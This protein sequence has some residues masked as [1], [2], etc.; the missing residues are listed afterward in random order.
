MAN[1]SNLRVLLMDD[2]PY[3][4]KYHLRWLRDEGIEVFE[5]KSVCEAIDKVQAEEFDLVIA[6]VMIPMTAAYAPPGGNAGLD[7]GVFAVRD[8]RAIK[9]SLKIVVFTN[10]TDQ[11]IVGRITA[12]DERIRILAKRS[13]SPPNFVAE[14]KRLI[15]EN[16]I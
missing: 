16:S 2:E 7:T 15:R 6:D 11:E 3:D 1:Q 14:V 4:L 13:F 8:L 9:K 10:V 12:L 5:A